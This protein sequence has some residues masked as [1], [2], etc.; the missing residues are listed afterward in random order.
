MA[1]YNDTDRI[2]A[3]QTADCYRNQPDVASVMVYQD[4][5]GNWCV[6]VH[7]TNGTSQRVY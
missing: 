6:D 5:G 4:S 7:Y 3:E 2:N 1:N